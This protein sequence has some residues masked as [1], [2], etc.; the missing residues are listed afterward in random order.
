MAKNTVNEKIKKLIEEEISKIHK[1]SEA[2]SKSFSNLPYV[3][4]FD[5]FGNNIKKNNK[6]YSVSEQT[7]K[8]AMRLPLAP[9][10]IEYIVD[11]SFNRGFTV[12]ANIDSPNEEY[13]NQ[14]ENLL[15][16]INDQGQSLAEVMKCMLRDAYIYGS[17]FVRIIPNQNK[18]L[19][20]LEN[21]KFNQIELLIDND[22]YEES[23]IEKITGYR[24][25]KVEYS[26]DEIIHYKCID[27]GSAYG[28]TPFV[29]NDTLSDAI[30]SFIDKFG[31]RA[32]NQNKPTMWVNLTQKFKNFTEGQSWATAFLA[33]YKNTFLGKENEGKPLVTFGGVEVVV[34]DNSNTSDLDQLVNFME[35][36]GYP[37]ASTLLR[38]P[39]SELL[40]TDAKYN[41]AEQGAETVLHNVIYPIQDRIESILNR[42]VISKLEGKEYGVSTDYKVTINREV[43]NTNV[44]LVNS[45]VQ[46]VN[47]GIITINEAREL[48]DKNKF[49][50]IDEEWANNHWVR[51]GNDIVPF[52]STYFGGNPNDITQI[53]IN[54]NAKMQKIS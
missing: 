51:S 30:L 13:K 10:G 31:S 21:I 32:N 19:Y 3:E 46:S 23:K 11:K 4:V 36:I 49:K 43:P 48:I 44:D 35:K 28:I 25:N 17:G 29:Y 53:D 27:N 2:E 15:I 54:A 34:L 41:N 42:E 40:N 12:V 14:L 16:D 24:I 8:R 38:I 22:L 6:I 45:T 39:V 18:G 37:H 50:E 47:S 7:V 33:Q 5:G 52:E 1:E 9:Q 20:G 26:I